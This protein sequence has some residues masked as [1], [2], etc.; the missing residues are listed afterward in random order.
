[1]GKC[2]VTFNITSDV[3]CDSV[4]L[5]GNIKELG[6]WNVEKALEAKYDEKSNSYKLVKQLEA[7]T[8]VAFK[9]CSANS[10]DNV[11]KGEWSSEIENHTFV[12]AKGLVVKAHVKYF[13]K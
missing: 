13:N 8:E 3:K 10:W 12:V 5:V 11:E 2:R 7:G 6:D 9:I 1:M 4:F